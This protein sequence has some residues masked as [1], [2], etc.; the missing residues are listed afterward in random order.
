MEV[1][2]QIVKIKNNYTETEVKKICILAFNIAI[3][4]SHNRDDLHIVSRG[5]T[6]VTAANRAIRRFN[7]FDKAYVE[8]TYEP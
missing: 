3:D 2:N 6:N 1:E 4:I 5:L 7:E 8:R